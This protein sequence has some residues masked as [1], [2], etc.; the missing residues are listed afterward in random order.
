MESIQWSDLFSV[1]IEE[2]DF[3]HLKLINLINRLILVSKTNSIHSEIIKSI[4]EEMTTYAQ[5]HFKTEERLMEAYEF[6]DI[7]EHKKR[8]LDFQ[9][10]TMDL[11]EDTERTAEQSADVLLDF[12]SHWLTHHILQEDMAYKDFFIGKGLR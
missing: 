3:Q 8:H 2:L 12:L 5:V 9:V 7:K 10:K 6:P 4:L 11:Y 1:G